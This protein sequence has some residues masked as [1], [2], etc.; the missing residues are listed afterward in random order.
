MS[1]VSRPDATAVGVIFDF[2][3][4]I[5][6]S[7]PLQHRAYNLALQPFGVSVDRAE[8]AREWIAAGRGPEHAVRTYG[9]SISPTELR[10]LKDPLYHQ[11][12]RDEITLVPG[13]AAAVER[14]SAAL[15]IVLATNSSAADTG[16]A[17]ERF[18]LRRYFTAVVTREQYEGAKPLP[19]AFRTAAERLGL[20]PRRCVVIEDA[21]KG[22]QAANA[23]G[24]PCIAF[25]HD[26]T[27]DNDV[28]GAQ[29]VVRSLDEVTVALVTSLAR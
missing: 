20:P 26:Y 22:V 2:D 25:P 10:R 27:A 28:S 6:D 4:V 5:I 14:L 29:A 24:C 19:D 18:D 23:A 11:L 21:W 12:L 13:A 1:P 15:P 9:L 8:Y 17:L 7:E 3:G 16:Y